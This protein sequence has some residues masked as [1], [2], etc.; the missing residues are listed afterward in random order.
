MVTAD[1]RFGMRTHF[2]TC[3]WSVLNLVLFLSFLPSPSAAESEAPC[4]N[5][6]IAASACLTRPDLA[7]SHE[8]SQRGGQ[9]EP[10]DPDLGWRFSLTPR[11]SYRIF[12]SQGATSTPEVANFQQITLDL[13]SDLE[14]GATVSLAPPGWRKSELVVTVL[15]LPN[16]SGVFETILVSPV[17][18]LAI[19][20]VS[21]DRLDFEA[22]YRR[23]IRDTD[24]YW[25]AGF[26]LLRVNAERRA[27]SV[28]QFLNS[29]TRRRMY[30]AK[31]GVGGSLKLSSSGRQLLSTHILTVF[32]YASERTHF[33]TLELSQTDSDATLG[34]DVASSYHFLITPSLML[35][36][37]YRI[38]GNTVSLT[39]VLGG[40]GSHLQLIFGA[41]FSVTIR[42]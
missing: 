17:P 38:Q 31:G 42:F 29:D 18:F 28:F 21:A 12:T 15:A 7:E 26:E 4:R 8:G 1:A 40:Q 24:A 39:G 16:I 35:N 20:E 41:E 27:P 10:S 32:G 11:L 22:L 5:D 23:G 9:A 37:G 25:V 19:G 13:T 30:L 33:T 2:G 3:P 6:D 14:F 34:F 36:T